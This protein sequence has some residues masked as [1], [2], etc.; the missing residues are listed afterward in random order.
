MENWDA[1]YSETSAIDASVVSPQ[2]L[3]SLQIE[4]A[5]SSFCPLLSASAGPRNY[6]AVCILQ[7][8]GFKYQV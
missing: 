6:L 5:I 7:V 2:H 4:V 8:M 1:V 3:L